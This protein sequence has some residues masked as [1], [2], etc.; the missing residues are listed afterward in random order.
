MSIDRINDCQT[1]SSCVSCYSLKH[2]LVRNFD[3]VLRSSL[4]QV[5]GKQ[6]VLRKGQKLYSPGEDYHG[7]YI[8]KTGSFKS[9]YYNSSGEQQVVNFIFPSDL[10]GSDGIHEHQ[11]RYELEALE[12]STVCPL[13][14]ANAGYLSQDQ[15]VAVMG[16][17]LT[18][19]S[20][21]SY[22]NS[23][24]LLAL[25]KLKVDQ[26]LAWFLLNLS[27]HMK[28]L[29][30]SEKELYLSMT[31][32]DIANHLGMANETT[33]RLFKQFESKGWIGTT[34]R[35]VQIVDKPAMQNLVDSDSQL[36]PLHHI[37]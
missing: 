31:R 13:L 28:K 7:L 6:K 33:S 37:S 36:R 1:N 23:C 15:T 2:C 10:I 26:R 11:Y 16:E 9:V 12:T 30:R 17:V 20:R 35:W 32:Y 18:E 21:Q 29:G 24:Y 4:Q 5:L 19:F 14:E 8:V 27:D 22:F 3:T 34:R 25:G